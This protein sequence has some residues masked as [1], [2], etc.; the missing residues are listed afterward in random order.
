MIAEW[1]LF[2][3]ALRYF[4]RIPV[5][6]AVLR[7]SP[8]FD[9][10]ARYLPLVGVVVGSAG[11]ALYWLAALVWPAS[12]A[13]LLSMLGIVLLTGAMHEQGLAATCALLGNAQ[14]RERALQAGD[15]A[16]RNGFGA[17]GLL[18]VQ[19]LRYDVLLGLS[20]A[21]LPFALPAHAALALTLVA[22]HASSRALVVSVIA[23]PPA[24]RISTGSVAFA[25]LTGFLPAT[26]LGSA[27]MTGLAAAIVARLLL[28][29][30]V[31]GA[32][33]ERPG[34]FLGATQQLTEVAFY[35]GALGAW[36]YT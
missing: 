6:A 21:R 15:L 1:R 36:T 5:P 30:S 22:G 35:L 7:G 23:Q 28:V 20:S 18:F 4:T 31:G 34:D 29:H 33:G 24:A 12:L 19:L 25:L 26:L 14:P 13:V 2:L 11:G 8:P 17:L 16:P 32:P 3:L 10:A 27:G 9:S